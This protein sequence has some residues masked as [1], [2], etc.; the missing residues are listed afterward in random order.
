MLQMSML[1]GVSN[2]FFFFFLIR[3]SVNKKW[4]SSMIGEEEDSSNE[5]NI[6]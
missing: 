1:W 6:S 2:N 5:G 4:V 3:M